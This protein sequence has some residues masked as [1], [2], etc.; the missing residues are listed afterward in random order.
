MVDR[1]AEYERAQSPSDWRQAT[2]PGGPSVQQRA[3]ELL[4][5]ATRWIVQH[6]EAALAGAVITGVVLGWLIKRR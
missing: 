2:P 1:L 4:G 3:E 5:Q 6:P